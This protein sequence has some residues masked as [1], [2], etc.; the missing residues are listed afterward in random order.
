MNEPN[1]VLERAV[2]VRVSIA[3]LSLCAAAVLGGSLQVEA[4]STS[5]GDLTGAVADQGPGVDILPTDGLA[6]SGARI[7]IRGL[8]T[9]GPGNDPLVFVDG[10]Q[11]NGDPG[12]PNLADS[13]RLRT[14]RL[15]D[16]NP[17]DIARIEVLRGTAQ[18]ARYGPGAAN[19]VVLIT[20][21]PATGSGLQWSA[22]GQGSALSEPDRH[23]ADNFTAWGHTNDTNH[24]LTTCPLTAQAA[25]SCT[26]DSLT[27]FNPLTYGPTSATRIGYGNGFGL[28]LSHAGPALRVLASADHTD[29]TGPFVLPHSERVAYDSVTPLA[30]GDN[31][32]RPNTDTRTHLRGLL[33]ANL[34]P[35]FELTGTAAGQY[36]THRSP[37]NPT[38]AEMVPLASTFPTGARSWVASPSLAGFRPV[39]LFAS[40]G[41]D[42]AT[43]TELGTTGTWRPS[44]WFTT[45]AIVGFD[46]A[47]ERDTLLATQPPLAGGASQ[48]LE[49]HTVARD[50]ETQW[51]ADVNATAAPHV[52][53]HW[54][55]STTVGLQ[56]HD[57]STRQHRAATSGL[58]TNGQR[59]NVAVTLSDLSIARLS[60]AAY[61]EQ[62]I[63]YDDRLWLTGGVSASHDRQ[64]VTTSNSVDPHVSISWAPASVLRVHAAYGS[65]RGE[66]PP[67]S[68][69]VLLSSSPC[70]AYLGGG[71]V[72]SC[73]SATPN[74]PSPPRIIEYEAGADASLWA[75]RVTLGATAYDRAT[76]G[77]TAIASVLQGSAFLFP[78]PYSVRN[79]GIE[80]DL[81]AVALTGR[82]VRW[83]ATL[84]ASINTNRL[85][86]SRLPLTSY[87]SPGARPQYLTT[88]GYPLYG[89]WGSPL[90]FAD[91]N[92]DGVISPTEVS[93]SGPPRYQGT[94]F[95][96]RTA[97]LGTALAFFGDRLRLSTVIDYVGGQSLIDQ[98]AALQM[99]LGTARAINDRHA[100]LADQAAAVALTQGTPNYFGRVQDGSFVRWREVSTILV[101][102]ARIA[103]GTWSR[104]VTVGLAVRNLAL[105]TRYTGV[106]P[107]V[108]TS[109]AGTDAI[110]ALTAV[111]IPREWILRVTL[112]N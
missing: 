25:G 32:N 51:T 78:I 39:T 15:G 21:R 10:V 92:G 18:T 107:E 14:G 19:G 60:R 59:P 28:R 91:A 50:L 81:S 45:R 63:G 6:G 93:A 87:A 94:P 70:V 75:S 98:N 9:L 49:T 17:D 16:V 34:G 71:V 100:S 72:S 5:T 7:R 58:L 23:P 80:G 20:M 105:W 3:W 74:F 83:N 73:N 38:L 26:L 88:P 108:N 68:L 1:G 84:T 24:T 57:G 8:S 65:A 35:T 66:W 99:Q 62:R 97:S 102:P 30:F 101:L 96:T 31:V 37:D 95:P 64:Y 56:N 12:G 13:T 40:E 89:I 86:S 82:P 104:S 2:C 47:V 11:V 69:A 44:T 61:L 22:Y 109:V 77:A 90:Q 106:D 110:S 76:S 27:R 111:A 103:R 41:A 55:L 42:N 54:V 48:V 53:P 4:Q 36:T 46:Q 29:Q 67:L 52:G 43:Q 112:G 85:V 33:G 79:R